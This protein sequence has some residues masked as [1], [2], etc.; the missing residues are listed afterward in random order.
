VAAVGGEEQAAAVG[1]EEQAAAGR[2][3]EGGAAAERGGEARVGR[4]AFFF[5]VERVG[6][7]TGWHARQ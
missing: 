2:G 1:G 4:F 6:R 5:T 3:G 7:G